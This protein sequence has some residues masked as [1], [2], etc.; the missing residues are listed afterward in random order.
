MHGQDRQPLSRN[1]DPADR[2]QGAQADPAEAAGGL[3]RGD[4]AGVAHLQISFVCRR[5]PGSRFRV[6]GVDPRLAEAPASSHIGAMVASAV[7]V[8]NLVKRYQ[9]T[10]AVNGIS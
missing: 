10:V 5:P 3:A 7:K 8:D 1:R 4:K 6:R 2:D 9:T